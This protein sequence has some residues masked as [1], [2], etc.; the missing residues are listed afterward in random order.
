MRIYRDDSLRHVTVQLSRAET[1]TW[2]APPATSTPFRER[3]RRTANA[4]AVR[5]KL[6]AAKLAVYASA[7][8]S[9]HGLLEIAELPTL[10]EPGPTP[11]ETLQA[12]QAALWPDG[13][14]DSDW[15]ADTLDAIAR[16]MIAGGY[17]PNKEDG[18]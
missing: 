13:D 4:F 12:I 18:P 10:P 16:T 14:P 17:G 11:G 15:S 8:V 3:V 6:R 9:K 5:H 7:A 1:V 2:L